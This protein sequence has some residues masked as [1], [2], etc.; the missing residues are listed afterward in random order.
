MVLFLIWEVTDKVTQRGFSKRC[1][2]ESV[3]EAN[4]MKR[5][6]EIVGEV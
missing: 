1:K 5:K 2:A 3:R 4:D 6:E